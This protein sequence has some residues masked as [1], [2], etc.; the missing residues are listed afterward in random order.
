MDLKTFVTKTLQQIVAGIKEAQASEG[1]SAINAEMFGTATGHLIN[2]GT[3]GTFT[4]VD[5]DVAI[6]AESS[7]GAKGS[8]KVFSVG[9]G[10]SR[11]RT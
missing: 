1:G 7:G 2:G 3:S 10:R 11:G 4:R 9:G 5:F 8:L 6:S